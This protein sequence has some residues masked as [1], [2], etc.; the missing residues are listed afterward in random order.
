LTRYCYF[1]REIK[2]RTSSPKKYLTKKKSLLTKKLNIEL[3]K[4]LVKCYVLSIALYGSE[5]WTLRQL[6][7]KYLESFEIWYWRRMEK[8]TWSEKVTNEQVLELIGEK[9]TILN[10]ILRRKANWIGH[11]LRRNWLLY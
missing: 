10:Y 5:T 8:I 1:T 11:I 4:K 3:R 6:E 9:R 2:K 7:R